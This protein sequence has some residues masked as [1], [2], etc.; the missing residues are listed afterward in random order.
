[1]IWNG[2]LGLRVAIRDTPLSWLIKFMCLRHW[3]IYWGQAGL[4][5]T[6]SSVGFSILALIELELVFAIF[7]SGCQLKIHHWEH[8]GEACG[9][10]QLYGPG[11]SI[12]RRN[13]CISAT[14]TPQLA[15]RL[16]LVSAGCRKLSQMRQSLRPSGQQVFMRLGR[17]IS[18][19]SKRTRFL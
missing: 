8:K 4:G 16:Q 7:W 10:Q 14:H 19:V 13:L 2:Q 9:L 18:S 12:L 17:Y 6:W 5:H 15:P 11:P 3:G 1:M